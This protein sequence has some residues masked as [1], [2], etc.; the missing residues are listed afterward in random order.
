MRQATDDSDPN[1]PP[2]AFYADLRCF[3]VSRD[4]AFEFIQSMVD[5]LRANTLPIKEVP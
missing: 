2:G 5:Q 1:V 3:G 4:Q